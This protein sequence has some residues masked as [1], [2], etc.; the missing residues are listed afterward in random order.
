MAFTFALAAMRTCA[1]V[2]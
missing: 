2:V 1:A